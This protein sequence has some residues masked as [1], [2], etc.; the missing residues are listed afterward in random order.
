MDKEKI[1]E[2]L[3]G[4]VKLEELNDEELSEFRKQAKELAE[5]EKGEVTGLREAKRA[6][7][8]R[9][10]KLRKEAEDLDTARKE[11]EEAL[12]KG[13]SEVSQFRSEQIEKA[14]ERFFEQFPEA[15]EKKDEIEEKFSKLDSGKI[16]SDLVL[17]DFVSAY[18]ATDPE[19]YLS[20]KEKANKMKENANKLNEQ[21]AG[22][23]QGGSPSENEPKKYSEETT[24]TAKAAGISEE[25]ADKVVTQG[26]K[27]T[28]E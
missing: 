19:G 23:P 21:E 6:E 11:Q 4:K 13:K 12:N 16:D 20:S 18:A 27:R 14:R 1:E 28:Y 3:E 9:V 26:M 5:K 24:N 25:A 8:E 15:L 7:T 22:S 10:E 2:A 17:K